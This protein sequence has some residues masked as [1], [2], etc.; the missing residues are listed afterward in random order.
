MKHIGR[1]K[2]DTLDALHGHKGYRKLQSPLNPSVRMLE[3]IGLLFAN[4]KRSRIEPAM[5]NAIELQVSVTWKVIIT[6]I[7][8]VFNSQELQHLASAKAHGNSEF[9]VKFLG[10]I[11]QFL[12]AAKSSCDLSIFNFSDNIARYFE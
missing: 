2:W 7:S 1:K 3:S 10:P 4:D 6:D 9:L 8:Y 11:F 12:Y 5:N